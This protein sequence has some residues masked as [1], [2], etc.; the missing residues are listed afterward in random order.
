M[1]DDLAD[2]QNKSGQRISGRERKH[3]N[4]NSMAAGTGELS[5]SMD[6]N[7]VS[8]LNQKP[9]LK[10]P[11]NLSPKS[12]KAKISSLINGLKNHPSISLFL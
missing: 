1:G 5:A 4:Y 2:N 11:Q 7:E 6:Y 8:G 9:G 12:V 3:V 10:K